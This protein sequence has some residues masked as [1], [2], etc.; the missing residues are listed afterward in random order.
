MRTTQA[1]KLS[2]QEAL[3]KLIDQEPTRT[4]IFPL[5]KEIKQTRSDRGAAILVSS[6]VENMLQT[7]LTNQLRIKHKHKRSVFGINGPL[8]SFRNKIIMSYTLTMIGKETY[9]NLEII[10]LV[11]NAFAHSK[12]TIS[13]KTEEIKNMC[14]LLILPKPIFP[15]SIFQSK[16]RSKRRIFE[17]ISEITALNLLFSFGAKPTILNANSISFPIDDNFEVVLKR[18]SLP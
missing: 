8:G 1:N 17:R 7:A 2:P 11:R 12:I 14:E 6:F 3:Q 4:I 18:K 15:F 13:F 16:I 5:I 10:R 9:N